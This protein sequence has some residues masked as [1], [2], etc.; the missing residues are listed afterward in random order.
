M[1]IQASLDQ[2][3][4][5]QQPMAEQFYRLFFQRCPE[6]EPFFDSVDRNRQ[7]L[8]LTMGLNVVVTHYR[9]PS[10][11]TAQYLQILGSKHRDLGVPQELFNRFCEALIEFL[12]NFHGEQWS[13]ELAAQ[14]QEALRNAV[15]I[16]LSGYQTKTRV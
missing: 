9:N 4:Q 15:K 13:E 11:A 16:M 10:P 14:W 2:L 7:T 8:L 12:A 6:A 5:T 3:L 1:D